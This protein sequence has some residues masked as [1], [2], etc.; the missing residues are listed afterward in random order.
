MLSIVGI[1]WI[2]IVFLQGDRISEEFLLE[3]SESYKLDMSFAGED[4]GYYKVFMPNFA[5]DEVFV[6]V[7]DDVGNVISEQSIHTKMSVMYFD[8]EKIGKYSTKI[9]NVSENPIIIQ[10]EFGDTNSHE[11]IPAGILILIGVVV[12]ILASYM[13]LKN[14]KIAQPD[15]NIT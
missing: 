7:L 15:E 1:I 6:Q 13:K 11:M 3:P 8:H 9:L 14:Y 2:S 10:V 12:I 4:I 5:G